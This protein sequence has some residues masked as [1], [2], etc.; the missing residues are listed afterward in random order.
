[1]EDHRGPHFA[2]SSMRKSE[3]RIRLCRPA[4]SSSANDGESGSLALILAD[5]SGDSLPVARLFRLSA[6]SVAAD[7]GSVGRKAVIDCDYVTPSS[8]DPP[9]RRK[10]KHTFSN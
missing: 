10:K 9:S 5:R 6:L 3:G 7:Y 1:M 8:W 2:C 4:V